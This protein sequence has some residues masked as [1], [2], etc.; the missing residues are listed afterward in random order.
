MKKRLALSVAME[1]VSLADHAELAQEAEQLGYTDA[2]SLEVDG[3]DVFT[4]LAL[5]AQATGMR[6]GTAI[7]NVFTRG[8]GTMAVS[9]AGIAE[10]APGRFCLGLGSGSRPIVESWNGGSFAR[11]VTRVREMIQVLRSAFAGERVA[12]EGKSMSVQGFRLTRPP[13]APIPIHVAAL[14]PGM[15]EVAGQA[16]DGV[17]INWLSSDDVHQSVDVVHKAAGEAGRDPKDV[18]IVARLMINI[19]PVTPESETFVRRHIT[20]YLTVPVYRAF[21]VWLGRADLLTP[22]WEAWDAGD[23]RGAVDAI[24]E[25]VIDDIILRGPI[26]AIRDQIEGYFKAGVDTASLRLLTHERDPEKSRELQMQ[27]LRRL[28]PKA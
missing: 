11:P 20:A 17:I 22:M 10:I 24:P 28:A 16:A 13:T 18:E 27:A 19:D 2:W 4:P 1:G 6:V 8:P 26:E 5:I 21:H 15:L 12:F 3:V 25:K 23:R 14:R 9:A 7:A